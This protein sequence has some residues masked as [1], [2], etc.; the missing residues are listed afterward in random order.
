MHKAADH[1]LIMPI[2][3]VKSNSNACLHNEVCIEEEHH[4]TLQQFLVLAFQGKDADK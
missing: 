3:A 4:R 1:F 2:S